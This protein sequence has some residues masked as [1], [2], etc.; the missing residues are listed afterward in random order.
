MPQLSFAFVLVAGSLP[1]VIEAVENGI[2]V[3]GFTFTGNTVIATE[4]LAGIVRPYVGQTLDL[5]EL[6]HVT[7]LLTE[8]YRSRG[9]SIA[10]VYIPEQDIRDGMVEIA[11][12]EGAVGQVKVEGNRHYSE[13]FIRKRFSQVLR[14]KALHHASLE[15]SLL[16]LNKHPNLNVTASL[17]PGEA[18][19][20]GHR[21]HS[22]G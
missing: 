14:E 7:E 15:R 18:P 13:S 9:Y 11:V 3:K 19:G 2:E 5:D 22:Q 20:T 6:Q 1:P 16:L 21:R 4:D 10:K 12:L 8:A 17:Q